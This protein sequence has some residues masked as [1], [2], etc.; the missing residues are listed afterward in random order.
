MIS[1]ERP[2]TVVSIS[3]QEVMACLFTAIQ[4]I[5][6]SEAQGLNHRTTY[7]RPIRTRI[8]EELVGAIGERAFAKWI[9][10]YG[11]DSVNTFHSIP[12]CGEF[13]VRATA[14]KAGSLIVRNNDADERRFVLACVALDGRVILRGWLSGLEAKQERW[15]KDPGIRRPS[16]FVPQVNLRKMEN[17]LPPY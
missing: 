9:G 5:T 6:A 11:G 8:D 15:K 7:D 1:S 17:L 4:R 13:E 16:W 3:T 2:A 14:L 12:D 10:V